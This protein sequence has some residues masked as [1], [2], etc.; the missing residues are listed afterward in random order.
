M[1]LCLFTIAMI[2]SLTPCSADRS[3][4]T[5]NDLG[6]LYYGQGRYDDALNAFQNAVRIDKLN[7]EAWNN[8]GVTYQTQGIFNE[9]MMAFKTAT[10]L[11]G[12]YTPIW[13][14]WYNVGI[15]NLG[16]SYHAITPT[17]SDSSD[18]WSYVPDDNRNNGPGGFPGGDPCNIDRGSD[19]FTPGRDSTID[20]GRSGPDLGYD[21]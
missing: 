14:R 16:V 6:K 12:G 10:V 18:S 5:W 21:S 1:V 8:L 7:A 15:L 2:L 9:A 13:N 20:I 17:G 19:S 4:A 3:A 11:S